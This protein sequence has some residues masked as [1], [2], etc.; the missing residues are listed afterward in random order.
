[1]FAVDSEDSVAFDWKSRPAGSTL[2]EVDGIP[3]VL[4]PDGLSA[5]SAVTGAPFSVGRL[6]REG[7]PV[8]EAEFESLVNTYSP[9]AAGTER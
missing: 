9:K 3:V 7:S 8:S 1:V 5:T 4:A 2:V 6:M